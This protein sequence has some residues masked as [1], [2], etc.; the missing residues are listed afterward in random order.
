MSDPTSPAEKP[1]P[2]M[3]LL[4]DSPAV[5]VRYSDIMGHRP[6]VAERIEE[7]RLFLKSLYKQWWISSF[8]SRSAEGYRPPMR[9]PARR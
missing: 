8:N 1:S 7:V 6:D 2:A 9:T 4:L 3:A 5:P